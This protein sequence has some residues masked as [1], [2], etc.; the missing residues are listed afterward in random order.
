[1][2]KRKEAPSADD[3]RDGQG[4]R[5]IPPAAITHHR[6]SSSHKANKANKP[7][8]VG[9]DITEA[10]TE[11]AKGHTGCLFWLQRKR[12]FCNLGRTTLQRPICSFKLA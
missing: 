2:K 11:M 12:R 4:E 7:C 8:V 10:R 1:M 3:L 9:V 6:G 5:R